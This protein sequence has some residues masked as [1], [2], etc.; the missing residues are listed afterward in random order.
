MKMYNASIAVILFLSS[1]L[2]A[3]GPWEQMRPEFP[4]CTYLDVCQW[5]NDTIFLVGT[6][7]ALRQSNDRGRH[8][9]DIFPADSGWDF[10]RAGKDGEFLYLLPSPTY[11]T[12]HED[13]AH[14]DSGQIFTYSPRRRT[15][16]KIFYPRTIS[17][18]VDLC[19]S[20]DCITLLEN[21][22]NTRMI[23]QSTDQG[24]SWTKN[25]LPDSVRNHNSNIPG[26]IFFQSRTRGI[27][28]G[29]PSE[30]GG[31]IP[32]RTI[33]GC[34]TWTRCGQ[35]LYPMNRYVDYHRLVP[36]RPGHWVN[37]SM[38]VL[39]DGGTDPV[40]SVDAGASWTRGATIPAPIRSITMNDR[41]HG[42]LAGFDGRTFTTYNSWASAIIIREPVTNLEP[43]LCMPGRDDCIVAGADGVLFATYDHGATWNDLCLPDLY[44]YSLHDVT[45]F[46]IDS[47]ACTYGSSYM[48]TTDGG[49]SWSR[50][51]EMNEFSVVKHMDGQHAFGFST[52]PLRIFRSDDGGGTWTK[53]YESSASDSLRLG[54]IRGKWYRSPDTIFIVTNKCILLSYN[55]GS[56]W[57]R[58][59]LPDPRIISYDAGN[60]NTCWTMGLNGIFLSDDDGTTWRAVSVFPDTAKSKPIYY[61]LHAMS[62]HTCIV[63]A[64][65]GDFPNNAI[66]MFT[67]SDQGLHWES[68]LT[69]ERITTTVECF[70]SRSWVGLVSGNAAYDLQEILLCKS[71]DDWETCSVMKSLRYHSGNPTIC[72]LNERT[73]WFILGTTIYRTTNGGVNWTQSP[74]VVED[75]FCLDAPYPNPV[76][77][78]EQVLW[79]FANNGGIETHL[80]AVV[81]DIRGR[82]VATVH[83]GAASPGVTTFAW[84][85]GRIAR[86]VYYLTVSAGRYFNVKAVVVR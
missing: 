79:S 43:V 84:N 27:L 64:R 32:W 82:T 68:H 54:N 29:E 42:Y 8:W 35:I 55:G 69:N 61:F 33:D 15:V 44:S 86:G 83:D 4:A 12:M 34:K 2:H 50:R 16:R 36:R 47:G 23:V 5:N 25:E 74:I 37:D 21:D 77:S 52:A 67:T 24:A 22:G 51:Y 10:V 11:L 38:V 58:R 1:S 75:Q 26:S 76:T 85:T 71:T 60:A 18:A 9:Q 59:D 53:S 62:S 40:V 73:G 39:V 81:N 57:M 31:F 3:Q 48:R 49:R 80:H 46:T 78:G 6:Y 72:F 30:G 66:R 65:V 20:S 63:I 41:G 28:L 56:T 7:G 45:F 19:V 70:P 17:T 13:T 14:I